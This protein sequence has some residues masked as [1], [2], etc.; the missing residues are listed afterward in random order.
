MWLLMCY[1]SLLPLQLLGILKSRSVK[2]SVC[3]C[4]CVRV[5]EC[6]CVCVCALGRGL[7][8]KGRFQKETS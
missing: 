8:V 7:F 5:C 6:A 2:L 1:D 4:V 3:V